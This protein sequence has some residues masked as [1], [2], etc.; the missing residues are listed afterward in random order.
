M[1]M[2]TLTTTGGAAT[3]SPSIPA[4]EIVIEIY[5][6]DTYKRADQKSWIMTNGNTTVDYA[7]AARYR[8]TPDGM[9]M[10]GGLNV[11]TDSGIRNAAFAAAANPGSIRTMFSID[12]DT[13]SIIWNNTQFTN[14]QAKFFRTPIGLV[15]NAQVIAKFIGP[16]T[17]ERSWT[18]IAVS[19]AEG[20]KIGS[21]TQETSD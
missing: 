7:R 3:P 6:G 21:L 4:G 1:A 2:G 9:L 19:G 5:T 8:I 11:A 20:K 13:Q 16:D 17:P 14:G 15:D 12:P 10:S 18:A